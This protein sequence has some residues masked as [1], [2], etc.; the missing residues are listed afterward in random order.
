MPSLVSCCPPGLVHDIEFSS[1]DDK[2]QRLRIAMILL[3]VFAM[4]LSPSRGLRN[5]V[6]LQLW[7]GRCVP[8]MPSVLFKLVHAC[9]YAAFDPQPV[10]GLSQC[11]IWSASSVSKV[12]LLITNSRYLSL[13]LVW[14]WSVDPQAPCQKLDCVPIL[15][16]GHL[17][18]SCSLLQ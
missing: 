12:G 3:S 8:G 4:V 11:G 9:C 13:G 18:N 16:V 7:N 1:A 2:C 6:S 17:S 5:A 14:S 15:G 10:P